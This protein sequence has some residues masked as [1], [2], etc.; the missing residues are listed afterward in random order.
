MITVEEKEQLTGTE[1]EI[2]CIVE[3]LTEQLQAVKWMTSDGSTITS[4]QEGL[5][6]DTGSFSGSSQTTVLTV[7]GPQNNQDT[8]YYCVVTSNELALIDKRTTVNLKVFSK[9]STKFTDLRRK[10]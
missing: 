3:G 5:T 1:A 10:N 9:C 4:G 7:S 6:L 2:S 8:T